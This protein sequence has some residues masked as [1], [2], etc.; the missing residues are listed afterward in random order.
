MMGLECRQDFG[1]EKYSKSERWV[2]KDSERAE[3]G[4]SSVWG[5]SGC[6][7]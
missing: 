4:L 3:L 5:S 6:R 7:W 1:V 2:R